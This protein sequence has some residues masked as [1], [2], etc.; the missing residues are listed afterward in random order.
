MYTHRGPLAA[1]A[2]AGAASAA[3]FLYL[4]NIDSERQTNSRG[5]AAEC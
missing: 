2:A 5:F 3:A 1:A 4:G